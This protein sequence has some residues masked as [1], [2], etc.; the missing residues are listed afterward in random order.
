MKQYRRIFP[1]SV[2]TKIPENINELLEAN[3]FEPLRDGQSKTTGFAL[4]NEMDRFIQSDGRHLF[5]YCE[6]TRKADANTIRHLFQERLQ[7]AA[8]E[9]REITVDTHEAIKAV[10]ER[11]A[12]KFAAI[13]QSGVYI[14]FDS[15]AGR[16]WCAGSTIKKCEA[17]LKKLRRALGSLDTDPVVLTSAG[18]RLSNHLKVTGLRLDESL[19]IP[20]CAKVVAT[21]ADGASAV[22]LDGVDL[23]D[24]NVADVLAD[25]LVRSI[26]VQLQK[27]L[28]NGDHEALALFVLDVPASSCISLSGLDLAGGEDDNEGAERHASDMQIVA[29]T[30]GQ[31]VN[32]ITAFMAGN[33]A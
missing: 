27:P 30:C 32:G 21:D 16:V 2:T 17:A 1:F 9:G 19:F 22:T 29:K 24:R 12:E 18:R 4:L 26:E 14:L 25:L 33:G 13:K 15:P 11:E 6:Q 7:K 23:R 20:A 3:K 31:I 28:E 10:A 8:D 5:H